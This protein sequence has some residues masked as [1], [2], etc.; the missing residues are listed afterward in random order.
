MRP[1]HD[2]AT[3]GRVGVEVRNL[4][5]AREGRSL[6]LLPGWYILSMRL[7]DCGKVRF[8]LESECDQPKRRFQKMYELSG[9]PGER[10]EVEFMTGY[11]NF[12]YTLAPFRVRF[13]EGSAA[14]IQIEKMRPLH[15]ASQYTAERGIDTV[16]PIAAGEVLHIVPDNEKQP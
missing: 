11:Q 9:K 15:R 1:E 16:T 3:A 13:L 7:K 4:W 14:D 2:A 12:T 10:A 8:V 6:P 5:R